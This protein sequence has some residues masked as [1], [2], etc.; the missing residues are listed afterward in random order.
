[1]QRHLIATGSALLMLTAS[2]GAAEAASL[3]L[4]PNKLGPIRIGMT[5]GQA[6]TALG[7]V[8]T[9]ER[10]PF[11]DS[12]RLPGDPNGIALVGTKRRHITLFEAF[13][14]KFR[15]TRGVRVGDT[16]GKL[17]NRYGNK[18][19]SVPAGNDLSGAASY[20]GVTKR[21]GNRKFLL[22]FLL[23]EDDV[24]SFMEA[25]LRKTVLGFG[26]CA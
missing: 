21:V 13:T 16:L 24:I 18:L 19:R 12:F 1:M 17:R 2:A 10:G 22:R 26:E 7:D 25:G 4:A 6:T 23:D 20:F 9:R 14:P 3:K 11:C 5:A 8:V 15:T